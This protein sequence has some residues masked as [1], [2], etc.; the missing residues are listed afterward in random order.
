MDADVCDGKNENIELM[1]RLEAVGMLLME[2][3]RVT[4]LDIRRTCATR[5]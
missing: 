3:E 1:I 2:L 5:L 4:Y